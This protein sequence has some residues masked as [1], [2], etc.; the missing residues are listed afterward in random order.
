MPLVQTGTWRR[1]DI[2]A[3]NR[4]VFEILLTDRFGLSKAEIRSIE[5]AECVKT[6]WENPSFNP[7]KVNFACQERPDLETLSF[8]QDLDSFEPDGMVFRSFGRSREVD[9]DGAVVARYVN[10]A[11]E[12]DFD[13]RAVRLL[14]QIPHLDLARFADKAF[15]KAEYGDDFVDLFR[16]FLGIGHFEKAQAA[17][18]G[19][20]KALSNDGDR[21][22]R[23]EM[24]KVYVKDL[25]EAMTRNH[26]KEVNLL[27]SIAEIRRHARR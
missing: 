11:P 15:A 17:L 8:L 9:V 16:F 18:V 2:V 23:A 25:E 4:R 19:L 20:K 12:R 5:D 24:A 6:Q 22:S 10:S 3:F 14:L 27:E 7:E 13:R 1:P 26:C 21:Q